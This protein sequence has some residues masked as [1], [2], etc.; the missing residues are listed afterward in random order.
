MST[1]LLWIVFN[2][3]V[4]LAISLDLGVFHRKPRSIGLR[5][6]A[7]WSFLWVCLS[8]AFG[9]GMR[10]WSGPEAA[11]S[12]FTGYLIEKALSVDNLF[13][14][15][16]IFRAFQIDERLQH[17][18]LAWGILGAL[19]MRGAMIAAGV[20]LVTRF[21]WV[22]YIFGVFLVYAGLHMIFAKEEKKKI[23][24]EE[25]SI[26]RFAARHLRVTKEYHGE[27]F[28][29]RQS[30]KPFATPLLL[31]LLVVEITDVTLAVD[32]IPAIFGITRD[33]FI[34]Y[35]S[36]VFAILG[37]RAMYFLLAGVLD[38]LRYLDE[39]LAAVLIFIGG[40]MLAEN[41]VHISVGVSLGVVCGLLL[42]ALAASFTAKAK[43]AT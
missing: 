39:G 3:F 17:R 42:I 41:W 29:V 30:G 26:F 40:K 22:M 4:L 32:S 12:F 14:F 9:L 7:L 37:L 19:V 8:I 28:F 13:L 10:F 25:N 2:L 35:T 23:H 6:A 21:S 16:V 18:I 33:A 36:N 11:L 15:L 38:R 5:E 27:R 43:A 24:P 31:V 20:A 1:P 34:V